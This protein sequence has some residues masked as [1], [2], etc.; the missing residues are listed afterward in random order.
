MFFVC[1]SPLAKLTKLTNE[2]QI[3]ND[4]CMEITQTNKNKNKLYLVKV[5]FDSSRNW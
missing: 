5:T 2:K 3:E 4:D 1:L